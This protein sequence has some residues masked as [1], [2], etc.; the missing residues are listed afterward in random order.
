M[1][2][3][4]YILIY[5]SNHCILDMDEHIISAENFVVQLFFSAKTDYL[6]IEFLLIKR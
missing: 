1:M 2:L 5:M 3:L 6:S 4:A